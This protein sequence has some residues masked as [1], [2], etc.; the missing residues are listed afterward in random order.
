[1]GVLTVLYKEILGNEI[2]S[3]KNGCLGVVQPG[4]QS[5]RIVLGI[6]FFPSV[7]AV[8]GTGYFGTGGKKRFWRK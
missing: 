4:N 7:R 5:V 8:L 1:M 6:E 2:P 3:C